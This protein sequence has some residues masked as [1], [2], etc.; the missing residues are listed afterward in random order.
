MIQKNF[1]VSYETATNLSITV[2]CTLMIAVPL[3]SRSVDRRFNKSVYMM[4]A[5]LSG[6]LCFIVFYYSRGSEALAIPALILVGLYYSLFSASIW[7]AGAQSCKEGFVDLGLAI[8][9]SVQSISTFVFPILFNLF[10]VDTPAKL[11]PILVLFNGVGLVVSVL[12]F[13]SKA[14]YILIPDIQQQQSST[15][16]SAKKKPAA[17]KLYLRKKREVIVAKI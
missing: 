11:L 12:I 2:P 6:I 5:A 8:M 17:P 3:V 16:Q 9:D 4:G 1:D 10:S 13:C 14:Q 15:S 7:S